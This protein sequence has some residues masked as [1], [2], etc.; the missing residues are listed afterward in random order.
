MV[1][2]VCE[3]LEFQWFFEITAENAVQ[4]NASPCNLELSH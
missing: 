1:F 3:V 4:Q 2:L